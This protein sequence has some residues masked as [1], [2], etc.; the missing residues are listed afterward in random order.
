MT[1]LWGDIGALQFVGLRTERF[2]LRPLVPSDATERYLGWLRD[3]DVRRF[4][5]AAVT[6]RDLVELRLYIEE[7]AQ[8][9]DV[10]FCGIFDSGTGVH[11]GNIKYE[12][13]NVTEG[14]AVM[15]VL[16]G[17]PTYRGRGVTQEVLLPSARWLNQHCGTAEIVLGVDESNTAAVKAYE[18]IGFVRDDTPRL[19]LRDGTFAMVWHL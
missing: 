17:D 15:G 19:A 5:Y 9:A 3:P 11:I 16:I 12:P 18:K 8:R 1:I 13:V 6:T 4:V 2:Y 10:L 7:R 14:Y